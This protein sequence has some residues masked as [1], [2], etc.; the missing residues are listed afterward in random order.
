MVECDYGDYVLFEDVEKSET[1]LKPKNFQPNKINRRRMETLERRHDH[2]LDRVN[3]DPSLKFDAAECAALNW[4]I[5]V[6][7]D[8]LLRADDEAESK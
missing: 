4:A 5:R 3:A 2:L 8:V 6:L 7:R 1:Y